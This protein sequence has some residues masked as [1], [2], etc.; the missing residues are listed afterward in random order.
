MSAV[1]RGRRPVVIILDFGKRLLEAARAG[2]TGENLCDVAI[3]AESRHGRQ[4]IVD[5]GRV[6]A[7]PIAAKTRADQ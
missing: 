6:P 2:R 3:S 4:E 5:L 7:T 1:L